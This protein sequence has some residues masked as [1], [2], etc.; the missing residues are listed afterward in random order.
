MKWSILGLQGR[1]LSS[2]LI[3]PIRFK[4]II[5]GHCS[6]EL[7]EQDKITFRQGFD[8]EVDSKLEMS[9]KSFLDNHTDEEQL[10]SSVES[11]EPDEPKRKKLKDESYELSSYKED[12]ATN[13]TDHET[14]EETIKDTINHKTDPISSHL[15]YQ[16]NVSISES[17]KLFESIKPEIYFND[18]KNES[19]VNE[20]F[21]RK[22]NKKAQDR[23]IVYFLESNL[24]TYKTEVIVEGRRHGTT[25]QNHERLPL[26]LSPTCLN[27]LILDQLTKR[28]IDLGTNKTIEQ[29]DTLWNQLKS[30]P[31]FI[32]WSIG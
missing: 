19:V 3:K 30:H 23:S 7:T 17:S 20:M 1:K 5:I 11:S 13:R 12:N 28:E 18:F 22:D 21:I 2:I 25:K 31:N 26:T 6:P 29:Y 16:K 4:S 15:S 9:L 10:V 32:R 14:K 27:E 8:L 24:T